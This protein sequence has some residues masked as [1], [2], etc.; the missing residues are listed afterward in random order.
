MNLPRLDV[1]QLKSPIS[2]SRL[3]WVVNAL[4]IAWLCLEVA[5]LIWVP[6][7]PAPRLLPQLDRHGGTDSPSPSAT[8]DRK[9]A[10][11]PTWVAVDS[12]H[13]FGKKTAKPVKPVTPVRTQVRKTRL[14]LKLVGILQLQ[15]PTHDM[16]QNM[17]GDEAGTG[18]GLVLI[19]GPDRR[20]TTYAVGDALPGG[21]TL[22][23]VEANRI[24][25]K[26][27]GRLEELLL[28]GRNDSNAAT[29][30]ANPS[31]RRLGMPGRQPR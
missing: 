20:Q 30:G 25:L 6:M 29:R 21:A 5:S 2:E 8:P 22:H 27:R 14:K 1:T 13:L 4:L 12:L 11:A 28:T 23:A 31:Q 16:A 9:T 19:E 18:Q 24:V 7:T 15:S 10:S 17:A 3:A 26:Y